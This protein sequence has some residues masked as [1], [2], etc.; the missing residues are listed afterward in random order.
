M[1]SFEVVVAFH[2]YARALHQLLHGRPQPDRFHVR[3]FQEQGTTT[4]PFDMTVLNGMSRFHLAAEAL[5]RAPR[6]PRGS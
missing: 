1:T 3:G 5:S 2:G 6:R 4:T